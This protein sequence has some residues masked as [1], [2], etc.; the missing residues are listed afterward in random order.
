MLRSTKKS[1]SV[2]PFAFGSLIVGI[3]I[4]ITGLGILTEHWK[5]SIS[6]D[7]YQ[8]RFQQLESPLYNHAR[9]S[10]PEYCSEGLKDRISIEFIPSLATLFRF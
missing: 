7:E 9:G 6:K 5:N 4:A 1:A 8:F 10:V 2:S 3:F